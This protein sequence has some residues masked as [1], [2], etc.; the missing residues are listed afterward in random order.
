MAWVVL[1]YAGLFAL[2]GG[3]TDAAA[4]VAAA[5]VAAAVA[6]G[7]GGR[8]RFGPNGGGLVALDDGVPL[9][10]D[11][12]LGVEAETRGR[13]IDR[14]QRVITK[15]RKGESWN[16]QEAGCKRSIL[17]SDFAI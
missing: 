9:L 10:R 7:T 17:F 5:A 2:V 1:G 4:A 13:D 15:H 8:G 14:K 11:E 16:S 3:E 12:L 6:A